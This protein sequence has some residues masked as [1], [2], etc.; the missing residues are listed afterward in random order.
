MPERLKTSHYLNK[1]ILQ[2]ITDNITQ[3]INYVDNSYLNN[4]KIATII[5]NP[6]PSLTDNYIW[7]PEGITNNEVPGLYSLLTYIHSKYAT[8]ASL[9]NSITN[10]NNTIN[11]EIQNLQTEINNTEIANPQNAVKESHYHTSHT[12]F[13]YQRN[14]TKTVNR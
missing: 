11:S 9:Q 6:T 8:L 10:K 7:I 4:N 3:T 12:D 13:M 2:I 5:I 1:L 14:N